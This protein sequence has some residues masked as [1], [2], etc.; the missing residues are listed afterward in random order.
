[1]VLFMESFTKQQTSKEEKTRKSRKF[2][3]LNDI[4]G[5]TVAAAAQQREI[6]SIPLSWFHNRDRPHRRRCNQPPQCL[7]HPFTARPFPHHHQL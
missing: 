1:M 5:R 7:L 6:L 4:G 2:S 3:L